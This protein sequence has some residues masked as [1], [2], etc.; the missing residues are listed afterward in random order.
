M[1]PV[2]ACLLNLEHG[3]LGYAREIFLDAGLQLDERF[4]R[5]GD[6]L[7]LLG[8][9]DALVAMGGEQS[10][11][12]A[13]RLPML[14]AEIELIRTATEAGIPYLGVCLGAQLLALARGGSVTRLPHPV[15][16]W[17]PLV[18]LAE[19]P[20]FGSLP[21]EAAALHWHED[22]FEPPPDAVELLARPGTSGSAFRVGRVAWGIQ[23]HP[24]ARLQ[25]LETWY[26]RWPES[27]SRVGSSLEEA[28]IADAAMLA[29]QQPAVAQA[30]FGAFAAVVHGDVA[31]R[32]V[33]T[34]Q[35]DADG[36]I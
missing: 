31:I 19:D 13:D 33:T 12:D 29:R 15:L 32:A 16:R 6:P 10:S 25:E 4:L 18:S 1:P 30:I 20:V 3:S 24:E 14:A 22:G 36:R 34:G 21:D 9:F 7:P 8:D 11:L 5:A 35:S 27:P 23:S 28:R 26:G 2:V 17:S